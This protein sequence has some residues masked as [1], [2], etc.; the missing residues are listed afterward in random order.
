MGRFS[1]LFL[2]IIWF[3]VLT[4]YGQAVRAEALP[5]AVVAVL[6][7][8]K[9]LRASDAAKDVAR[10]IKQYRN[11][12]RSEIQADEIRLRGVETDL[13]NQRSVLSPGAFEEQRQSFKSQVLEAQ[14]RGQNRKRQLDRAYKTAMDSIQSSVIPIV[15]E[16][17]AKK[18][19]TLVIDKSQVLFASRALDITGEVL[20][21]LNKNLRTITV[22]KP[23]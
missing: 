22:P 5:K 1:A 9:I 7:Y 4:T 13:K 15:E 18:G 11:S 12:F 14:K 19:F 8:A 21:H 3:G 23:K 2:L 17:T 10:Q 20:Q 16:L 6:D